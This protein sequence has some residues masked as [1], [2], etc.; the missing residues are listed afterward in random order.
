MSDTFLNG[1][2]ILSGVKRVKN[3]KY[4][5][6]CAASGSSLNSII[7]ALDGCHKNA[8]GGEFLVC[9]L[10]HHETLKNCLAQNRAERHVQ[11][12][13]VPERNQPKNKRNRRIL[14]K[15]VV[16]GGP[17]DR[18]LRATIGQGQIQRVVPGRDARDLIVRFVEV[19]AILLAPICPHVSEQ[20]W[21]LLGKVGPI[22]RPGGNNSMISPRRAASSKRR[23]RKWDKSTRSRS[24]PRNISWRRP[25]RSGCT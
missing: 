17:Q 18:L 15:D 16:Q 10:M 13:G 20:V 19:Q 25:I 3:K 22:V 1:R 21:K 5:F 9:R 11:R 24:N 7:F 8:R 12:R 4:G 14:R 6:Y 2:M 23:G